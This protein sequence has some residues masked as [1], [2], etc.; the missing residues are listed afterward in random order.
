[1]KSEGGNSLHC[2]LYSGAEKLGSFAGCFLRSFWGPSSQCW[3]SEDG[4]T[5]ILAALL[6]PIL[7][8]F[9]GFAADVGLLSIEKEKLQSAADSAAIAGAAELN[10]GDWASAAQ[11]AATL[12]GFTNG[13]NGATVSVNPSGNA[14]PTPLYG[15]HAG[16]AGYVEVIV[17]Q[18]EP[19]YFMR[20]FGFSEIP[21]SV[22]AVAGMGTSANCIYIL[23]GSGTTV[24]LSN[25]AQLNSTSCGLVD[26][27]S[28]TPAISVSGSANIKAS[29]VSVVGTTS[30]DNS[31]SVI[32]PTAMTGI[33]PV[34]DPLAYLSPPSYTAGSC[35]GDPASHYQGGSSYSVGPGSNYSSTQSGN[36]VCYTSLTLGGNGNTVTINPGVYVVTGSL[37]FE[38]GTIPGGDGVTFYLTGNGQLTIDNGAS[39]NLSAPTSGT[40]DGI[41]FYQDRSDSKSASI[42]GGASESLKGILY[43]PDAALSIGNGSS[44][45]FYSPIVANTLTIVGGSTFNEDDY[46][47][48]NPSSPLQTPRLVE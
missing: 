25:D 32:S 14:T 27:S 42:Q 16:Q 11:S 23:S 17:T 18:N 2:P 5:V 20:V 35:T 7:L 9:L 21:V 45:T 37:T 24:S 12:N 1:M 48:I 28:G 39:F 19:T 8:G 38:S 31:G 3:R 44:S 34:S 10:Y 46:A 22:R 40:Y 13:A 47:T 6:F 4:Q 30:T 43:F 26:D 15:S 41:L 29:S 36:L 33:V